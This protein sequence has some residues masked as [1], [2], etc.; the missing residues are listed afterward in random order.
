MF[1]RS[2]TDAFRIAVELKAGG[3]EPTRSGTVRISFAT[4]DKISNYGSCRFRS[5]IGL[6]NELLG[7][8]SRVDFS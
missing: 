6:L 3:I 4:G 8:W 7:Q 5:V 1:F 2:Y